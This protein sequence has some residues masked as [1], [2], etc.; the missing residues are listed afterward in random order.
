MSIENSQYI[1]FYY[2]IISYTNLVRKI[3]LFA[4][5]LGLNAE[6]PGVRDD[7]VSYI[8][9]P[10][11]HDDAAYCIHDKILLPATGRVRVSE[12]ILHKKDILH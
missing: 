6:P 4:R 2:H 8:Q 9:I 5:A 11:V 10:S 1:I 7:R 12:I 3:S